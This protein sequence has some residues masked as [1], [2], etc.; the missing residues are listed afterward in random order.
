MSEW[1][2]FISILR[3]SKY[4]VL[5]LVV[6]FMLT[7]FADL[8]IAIEVGMVLAA[9]LFMHR[10][11]DLSVVNKVVGDDEAEKEGIEDY[12][13]LPKGISVYEI[14]G[15]F[16]FGAANRYKE[17][18]KEAGIKSEMLIL[19]MRNVPFIDATGMHN[20]KE[21]L[22]TLKDY[23]VEVV[24]SGVRPEVEKELI[25]AGVDQIIPRENICAVFDM[26]KSKAVSDL[27]S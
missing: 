21:V 27:N 24:L 25:A 12:S 3:G 13:L 8:T 16:F 5:V 1:R 4:D 9:L 14:N 20:F 6:T 18:L 23:K 2:S 26:A 11:S 17:V 10:M 19:R 7:V 15:P 22:R